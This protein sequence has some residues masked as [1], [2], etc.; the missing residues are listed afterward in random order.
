[1]NTN[2]PG[3]RMRSVVFILSVGLLCA[4]TASKPGDASEDSSEPPPLECRV[5]TDSSDAY[6]A[7]QWDCG[8]QTICENVKYDDGDKSFDSREAAE[9]M[10]Q[11][12]VDRTPGRLGLSYQDADITSSYSGPITVID[13]DG[14]VLHS[15]KR[16]S[17]MYTDHYVHQPYRLKDSS[18]FEACLAAESDEQMA[19]CLFAWRDG[20]CVAVEHSC[21]GGW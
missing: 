2:V 11:A 1:M 6:D 15:Y 16:Y 19:E 3:K 5:V 21:S 20:D 13:A 14:H 9:C 8:L 18:Y 4:C 17:D 7:L 12:F 10:L